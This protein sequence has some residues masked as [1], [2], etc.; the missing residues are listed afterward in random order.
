MAGGA[1]CLWGWGGP[2]GPFW[3]K[4]QRWVKWFD[5]RNYDTIYFSDQNQTEWTHAKA[6]HQLSSDANLWILYVR[7]E[8]Q[9]PRSAQLQPWC[10]I[11]SRFQA[12]HRA[13]LE[14]CDL[15]ESVVNV[16]WET[17]LW[18]RRKSE[19]T[20]LLCTMV[21]K[22]IWTC[23]AKT[24][25]LSS[26]RKGKYIPVTVIIQA[27]KSPTAESQGQ[28]HNANSLCWRRLLGIFQNYLLFTSVHSPFK[29]KKW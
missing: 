24:S 3:R 27:D 16:S 17:R 18:P 10:E 11:I 28:I 2:G 15:S 21:R 4:T 12:S 1:L 29:R 13:T 9:I 19:K 22:E 25:R 23:P 8:L 5:L 7:N 14:L 6:T 26:V 20:M